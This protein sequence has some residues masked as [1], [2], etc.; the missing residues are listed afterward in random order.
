MKIAF[1]SGASKQKKRILKYEAVKKMRTITSFS[2]FTQQSHLLQSQEA[3]VTQSDGP[4]VISDIP[5][6][7]VTKVLSTAS[8]D[9]KNVQNLER[10]NKL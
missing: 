2:S 8:L 4:S 10:R 3:L 1:D 5:L 7:A 6:P 9:N